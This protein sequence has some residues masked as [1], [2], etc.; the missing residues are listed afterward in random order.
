MCLLIRDPTILIPVESLTWVPTA[1]L[2]IIRMMHLSGHRED[3]GAG[4]ILN[5]DNAA[6]C[7]ANYRNGLASAFGETLTVLMVKPRAEMLCN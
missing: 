4:R 7:V 6:E 1:G 5:D 3:V 2:T